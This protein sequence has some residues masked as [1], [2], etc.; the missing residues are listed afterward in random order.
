MLAP[1]S[2]IKGAKEWAR[3]MVATF[4]NRELTILDLLAEGEQ[5]AVH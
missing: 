5:V 3:S 1:G 4:G 2:D